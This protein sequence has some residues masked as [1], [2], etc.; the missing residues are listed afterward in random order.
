MAELPPHDSNETVA[1][2]AMRVAARFAS[3]FDLLR[4]P[5]MRALIRWSGFPRVFQVATLIVFI[6]LAMLSW[7]VFAPAGV[8]AKMF[9][10]ANLATLVIWGLWWPAMVWIAVLFGRVWCAVCPLEWV[11]YVGERVGRRLA[12]SQ[13]A[14]PRRMVAG[15]AIVVLYATIQ[16]LVAGAHINRVPAYTSL[17]LLGLLGLAAITGFFFRDRAFC[18]GFC[19]VG[20]LLN[21]YGRGGMI[22]VRPGEAATTCGPKIDAQTCPSLLNPSKLASN[23]NCLVCGRCLKA[24][25]PKQMRLLLRRPFSATDVREVSAPWS[26]TVFVMVVSGFVMGELFTESPHADRI[27]LA[28]P[29][30]VAGR[31]GAAAHVGWFEGI[32]ILGIV[33]LTLWSVLA[34]IVRL[35]GS[36]E[37]VGNLWRQMALP[38]GLLVS[39]G[40]MSKGVAKFVSW[41]PFLPGALRDPGGADTARAIAGK[42]VAAPAPWIGITAVVLVSSALIATAFVF[43]LRE[44]RL[45][46]AR[47]PFRMTEVLPLCIVAL[48]FLGILASWKDR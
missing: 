29:I 47:R 28:V 18:R 33:P 30:W 27:F 7:G 5:A 23:A 4:I 35:F 2:A 8:N 12:F 38:M 9:A 24:A 41:A 48:V 10:K 42:A 36:S 32:W 6:G 21:V 16:L 14:L 43:S 44:Y 17:F 19:P 26:L 1:P 37:S 34:G 3:G 45:S 25:A 11:A 46:Q 13:R 15:S 39:A 31:L 40:H 22:A 20:V